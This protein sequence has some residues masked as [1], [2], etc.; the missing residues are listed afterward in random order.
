[1]RK[2]SGTQLLVATHN[3]GKLDEISNLL[4]DFGISVISA[5]SLGLPEPEETE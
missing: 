1:M 3:A 4:K 2:F 5:A